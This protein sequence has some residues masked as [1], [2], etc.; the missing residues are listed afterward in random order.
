[1]KKTLIA[2]SALLLAVNC[3]AD[4]IPETTKPETTESTTD[5]TTLA[6]IEDG[7]QYFTLM[8]LPSPD[9]EVIVFFSFN[10]PSCFDFENKYH[11]SQTISKALPEGTKFKRY[12]LE[13][14][15][16][17][18]IE[19]AQAW[20][21]ANILGIEDKASVALYNEV[22][23]NKSIK[24]AD[25]IKKLFTS[26]GVSAETYD[27]TK[28]SFLVKAFM[29]QQA[30]AFK[31]IQPGSIPS[32]I[33]NRKFYINSQGLDRTSK[34]KFE[35]DYARVVTYLS[36]LETK[37]EPEAAPA[38]EAQPEP[39]VPHTQP[40]AAPAAEA[41]PVPAT[42]EA[43]PAVTPTPE[44][45]P[46]SAVPVT[47][48]E[49]APAAEAQPAPATPEAQPAVTPTPEVTPEPAVPVTQPEA[50]PAAEAQPAPATPEAQP[51]VTPTP[52]VIPEPSVPDTQPE[53]APS[54]EAQPMPATPEVQ[55]AVTPTPE[56]TPESAV[57][58]TQPEAAPAAE[59]QP[60]PATPEAQP[61]VTP[62]PEVN[63]EPSVP[64]TQPEVA[65]AAEAQPVRVTPE[66][67]PAVTPTP[68]VTPESAVPDTQPESTP[69]TEVKSETSE[70]RSEVKPENK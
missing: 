62:T 3:F 4:E 61:A 30:E 17:L 40:E 7:K 22:Q 35:D 63:P 29:N 8:G 38:Q 64:V 49:A 56:I 23:T 24:T 43:Q 39:S 11:R 50:A 59:A 18:S 45:N 53:A 67:Q 58:V 21:V 13:N 27:K 52:E 51:A 16:K 15:G 34:Q 57:P 68:E 47:Q 1:M 26:L 55:P 2:M 44:V 69:A 5:A 65:P 31:E 19:L 60:V 54:V 10:S 28:D 33:V 46:E 12:H 25:D 42:P 36:Q 20:A 70:A 32:V 41:Q 14:F 9:K 66:A 48:P 6:P 37:I